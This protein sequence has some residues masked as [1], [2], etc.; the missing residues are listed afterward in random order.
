MAYMSL[1]ETGGWK[2]SLCVS[3]QAA[4]L[5]MSTALH[6]QLDPHAHG[7][8]VLHAQAVLCCA[9]V[10]SHWQLSPH[11]HASPQLHPC[12]DVLGAACS[13]HWQLDPH[14]QASS[15]LLHVH[16]SDICAWF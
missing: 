14:V 7:P 5:T 1:L 12:D 6:W 9:V 3:S 10:L 13:P 4:M 2:L 15:V 16:C 8:P 11:S